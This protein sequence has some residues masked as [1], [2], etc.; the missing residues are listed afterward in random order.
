MERKLPKIH[1]HPNTNLNFNLLNFNLTTNIM[2]NDET[3]EVIS[4]LK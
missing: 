3:L 1:T 4:P 2:L